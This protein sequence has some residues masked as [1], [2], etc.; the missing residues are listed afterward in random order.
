MVIS[1]HRYYYFS[2]GVTFIQIPEGFSGLAQ[3]VCCV[4]DRSD[5]AGFDE[6]L[7]NN[8][9]LVVRNRKIGTSLPVHEQ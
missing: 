4:D 1:F 6:L 9:V 3:R 5:L 7:Q 2:S 8:Q